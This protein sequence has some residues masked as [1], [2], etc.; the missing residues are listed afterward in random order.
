MP[1]VIG[2]R[3]NPAAKVYYFDPTGFEDL[4]VG[5]FVVVATARGEEA[6]KVVIAPHQV[7]EKEI[8]GRLK[9]VRRRAR[10]SR[11]RCR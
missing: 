1:L 3:F 7:D 11:R 5:E 2:V 4:E 6:G 9:A 10:Q 8:V